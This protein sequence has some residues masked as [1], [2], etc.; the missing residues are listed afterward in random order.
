MYNHSKVETVQEK[1][2][3][4]LLEKKKKQKALS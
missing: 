3:L 1:L 4:S 2:P